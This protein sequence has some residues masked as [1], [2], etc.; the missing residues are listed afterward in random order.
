MATSKQEFKATERIQAPQ[1]GGPGRGPMGGGMVGQKA[2]DFVPS[3][4]RLAARLRPDRGKTVLVVLLVGY[5]GLFAWYPLPDSENFY[6]VG[7]PKVVTPD[8]PHHYPLDSFEAHWNKNSNAAWAFDRWWLNLFPR[9]SPF[10]FNNGGY[11]TLS[12]IPT[13]GT[14][15]LG[16]ICGAWIR[17]RASTRR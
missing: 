9:E 3:A 16:L 1:G 2:M 5:W 8:W 12:F 6:Q 14:M 4:K 11:A 17:R 10:Q 7:N 15:I 13:L